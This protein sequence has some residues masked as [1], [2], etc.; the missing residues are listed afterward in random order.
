MKHGATVIF[1]QDY[2][3]EVIRHRDIAMRKFEVETIPS[4]KNEA[5]QV[6]DN[7]E[8]KL[9][10]AEC[11]QD[12]IQEIKYM[13]VPKMTVIRTMGGRELPSRVLQVI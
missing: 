4:K 10:D 5:K 13:E 8:S 6:L 2:I 12:T 7:W 9:E 11:F 3:D 1:N